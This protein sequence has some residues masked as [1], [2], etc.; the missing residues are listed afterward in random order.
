[1]RMKQPLM[2]ILIL[3]GLGLILKNLTVY[4]NFGTK[5]IAKRIRNAEWLDYKK[6]SRKPGD[7]RVFN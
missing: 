1:M 4:M 6:N 5:N 2:P 3:P 7:T